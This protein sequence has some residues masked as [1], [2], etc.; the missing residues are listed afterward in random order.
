MN[1]FIAGGFAG[2]A[3]TIP[4]TVFMLKAHKKLPR[5]EQYP[6]PPKE[7]TDDIL[8]KAGVEH[9]LD[10]EQKLTAAAMSHFGYGTAAGVVYGLLFGKMPVSPTAKGIGYGMAVWS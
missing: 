6:L 8:E 10:E 7:I 4:M 2:F 3:A 1:K 5:K 9:K